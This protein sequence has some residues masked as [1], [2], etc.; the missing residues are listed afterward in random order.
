MFNTGKIV[1]KSPASAARNIH[2]F[3]SYLLV[4]FFEQEQ[5]IICS[6]SWS[7]THCVAQDD[8]EFMEF[9]YLDLLKTAELADLS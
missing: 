5:H 3:F 1:P 9:F 6:P 7:G 4:L 8:F 2:D